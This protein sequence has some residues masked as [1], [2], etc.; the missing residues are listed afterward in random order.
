MFEKVIKR[1]V[2][3]PT[4][5]FFFHCNFVFF[6]TDGVFGGVVNSIAIF[7]WLSAVMAPVRKK[8][9]GLVFII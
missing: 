1:E 7:G 8:S 3:P 4:K 6:H 9:F 5:F 2:Y